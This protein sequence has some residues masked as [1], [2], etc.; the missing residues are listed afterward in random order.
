VGVAKIFQDVELM[1]AFNVQTAML[2][3]SLLGK[4]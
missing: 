1:S 4:K 3:E 2:E